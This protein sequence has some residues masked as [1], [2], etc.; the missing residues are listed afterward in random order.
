[1]IHWVGADRDSFRT[2]RLSPGLNVVLGDRTERSSRKDSRNGLGK[3]SLLE[4]IHFCLG[5]SSRTGDL[6]RSSALAGWTFRMSLDVGAECVTVSRA[7]SKPGTVEV[8]S[9]AGRRTLRVAEWNDLLGER[10]FGLPVATRVTSGGPGFRSLISYVIRRGAHAYT[11]PFEN[12]PKQAEWDKQVNVAYLLGLAWSDAS[13]FQRLREKKKLLDDLR[14]ASGTGLMGEALGSQGEL[15]ADRVR[16]QGA[17]DDARA[18]LA[19]FRVHPQYRAIEEEASSLTARIHAL[20]NDNVPDRNI[21]RLYRESLAEEHPPPPDDVIR[22]YEAAQVELPGVVKQRLSDLQHFHSRITENR[23][24][25]LAQEIEEIERRIAQREGEIALLSGNRAALLEILKT[26]GALDEYV[27][28]QR[29]L[30]D[31]EGGLRQVQERLAALRRFE[32]GRG[33]LKEE[34]QRLRQRAQAD[35]DERRAIREEAIRLFNANSEALYEAPGR[36]VIDVTESGFRYGVE[37]ERSGAHGIESMKVFCFDL[38]VAQRWASRVERPGILVHD[39][40]LF[41][42]VDSRQRAHALQLVA[43]ESE[44]RGFQY[45]C[46]MNSDQI[47]YADFDRGFDFDGRVRLRL[48]DRTA[49]GGLFGIR[50]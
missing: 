6:M 37:I 27:L 28:L 50:F 8:E 41:D 19:A 13:E 49:D 7:T 16:L 48:T 14:R 32:E 9:A 38:M 42:P 4:I 5:S 12:F 35:Y 25:F 15:E 46:T 3:T 29:R 10:L 40:T 43:R 20:A 18:Q 2:V 1:M 39:S 22:L 31:V 21:L 23:R 30:G 36:L 34:T 24:R 11:H 45:I 17:V 26:H 47:P 44:M 33:A